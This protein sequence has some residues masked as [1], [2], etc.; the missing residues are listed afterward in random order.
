MRHEVETPA[1]LLDLD[2]ARRNI[3]LMATRIAA[4]GTSLRPHVKAHKSPELA[5]L[6]IAAGA[7]GVACATVWEAV[8]MARTAGIVD[9]LVANEVVGDVKLRALA[10]VARDH[11]ITVAVDDLSNARG[12]SRAAVAAGSSFELL[13][14]VDVGMGRAGVRTAAQ[15][16]ALALAVDRLPGL[17]MRGVQG[18]EGHS[19]SRSPMHLPT[20]VTSARSSR[21]AE[22]AATP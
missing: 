2:L 7:V 5:R 16:L 10:T 15:A 1:R 22:P 14:E 3:A 21:P 13:I 4:L 11:R 17:A 19:C 20:P 6:Q 12:L 18:Y 9:I 8:V